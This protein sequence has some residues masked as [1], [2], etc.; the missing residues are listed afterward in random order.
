MQCDPPTRGDVVMGW[1]VPILETT[2][3]HGHRV[4]KRQPNLLLSTTLAR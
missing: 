1:T 4:D 3:H 2:F